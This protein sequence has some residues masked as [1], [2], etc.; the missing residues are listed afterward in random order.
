MIDLMDLIPFWLKSQILKY[1]ICGLTPSDLI[2]LYANGGFV[3][4]LEQLSAQEW[5]QIYRNDPKVISVG[6]YHHNLALKTNGQIVA[7]VYS[8][9]VICYL[10]VN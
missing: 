3:E 10:F 4:I 9:F 7:W 6:S 1:Y 2:H 5:L 8:F